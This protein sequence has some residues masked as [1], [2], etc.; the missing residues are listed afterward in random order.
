M[1]CSQ[2]PKNNVP[3]ILQEV[4]TVR[5]LHS[6]KEQPSAPLQRTPRRDPGLLSPR[7]DAP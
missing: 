2:H 7:P 3:E 5:N 1:C 4:K 6:I